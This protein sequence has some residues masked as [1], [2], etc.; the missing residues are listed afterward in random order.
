MLDADQQQKRSLKA[1]RKACDYFCS[2][3]D[4]GSHYVQDF[5]QAH[6]DL[7]PLREVR[8]GLLQSPMVGCQTP[9]SPFRRVVLPV[10]RFLRGQ[11][12]VCLPNY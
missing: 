10:H 9:R 4:F 12:V 7:V 6:C 3:L 1:H 8:E 5:C 2:N 11:A